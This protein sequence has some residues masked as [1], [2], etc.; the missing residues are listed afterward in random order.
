MKTT[1]IGSPIYFVLLSML[2][3][4]AIYL[5]IITTTTLQ[6]AATA[7]T[8][9]ITLDG[10][11]N[12]K[13]T[14]N[15]DNSDNDF[16]IRFNGTDFEIALL[17]GGTFNTAIA[18]ASGSGSNR[19][20]IPESAVSG[21]QII[22]D[23]GGGDDTLTIDIQDN[24]DP[25]AKQI[26]FNG[27]GQTAGDALLLIGSATIAEADFFFTNENDGS[28]SL[29]SN[30]TIFY[31]GL[32][33]ITSSINMVDVTLNYGSSSETISIT[34]AGSG[35]T[36]VDSNIGGEI[37]TFNN[38]TGRLEINGGAGDDIIQVDSL[39]SQYPA[40]L[41]FSGGADNDSIQ[42]ASVTWLDSG[43]NG[44]F[45]AE[46][47]N[48]TAALRVP[49]T[50]LLDAGSGGDIVLTNGTNG[51]GT[52]AITDADKADILAS[53]S[54]NLETITTQTSFFMESSSGA[55]LDG[56]GDETTNIT[57][58]SVALRAATGIGSAAT[59]DGDIDLAAVSLAAT[60]GTGDIS[61]TDDGGIDI[62]SVDS[63]SGVSITSSSPT[64]AILL[65]DGTAGGNEL[66]EL[67]ASITN[68]SSGDITIFAD[69]NS[70]DDPMTIVSDITAGGG[71]I[72]LV[73]YGTVNF[74]SDPI[75]STIGTGTISIHGGAT[76]SF[77]TGVD[78]TAGTSEGRVT[79]GTD[80]TLLTTQGDVFLT[81]QNL[82][83]VE[84]IDVDSDA[85]GGRGTVRIWSDVDGNGVGEIFDTQGFENS[86]ITAETLIMRSANGIGSSS[87]MEVTVDYLAAYSSGLFGKIEINN[88][89]DVVTTTSGLGISGIVNDGSGTLEL[90]TSGDLHI[91]TPIAGTGI[92]ELTAG[93]DI[94]D[95][96]DTGTDVT[97]SFV[98][99]DWVVS[100]G[101]DGVGIFS[102]QGGTTLAAT[103]G[104][105]V[106][107]TGSTTAGP[108][109]QLNVDGNVTI[110][111]GAVFTPDLS[112]F[113]TYEPG[114]I[115]VIDNTGSFSGEF[116]G[117]PDLAQTNPGSTPNFV[118]EYSSMVLR[119]YFAFSPTLTISYASPST[120]TLT[121]D[122][123]VS[124]CAYFV[125]RADQPYLGPVD[126]F[127]KDVNSP[128]DDTTAVETYFYSVVAEGCAGGTAE[129][130]EVGLF[131]FELTSGN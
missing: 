85:T 1:H 21:P 23:A 89:A 4:C 3:F 28:I 110:D 97:G 53:T 14:E 79:G 7:D 18:G 32:E 55:L 74:D 65:R 128:F 52:L 113:T 59:D 2:F 122:E 90:T 111:S 87:G 84:M 94:A 19:V 50:V 37:V 22:F 91:D 67:N 39:L 75:V 129:S 80:Y 71:D 106:D 15:G 54:V 40:N 57:S 95:L 76:Y 13:I 38:P 100:P 60:T 119:A 9:D 82:I 35:Q 58:G 99:L 115:T 117:L 47:I 20:S 43:K 31:T 6:A 105:E 26:V 107:L 25:F 10:S 16:A 104:F 45:T 68:A 30:G 46:S 36:T 101:G 24:T 86:F 51:M 70:V 41:I 34:N 130:N 114:A 72:T 131:Y 77:A 29:T 118:V 103:S 98:T 73:A 121:W 120:A 124:N 127:E 81:A 12:L 64:G 92:V 125:F 96:N 62:N 56:T 27:E 44:S 83:N 48:Q 88:T 49:G 93:G 42:F 102:V 8:V 61:I 78:M 112:A 11:N 108:H 126:V 123:Y 17:T 116:A 63:L 69:G 66:M 5:S 109:D 33:P